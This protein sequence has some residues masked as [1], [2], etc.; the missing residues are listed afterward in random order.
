MAQVFKNIATA[1]V[2]TSA[3]EAVA[4]GYFRR[5]EGV[6]FDR[7]RQLWEAKRRA[8][9]LAD[10]GH[11]PPVPRSFKLP[12]ESGIATLG[13][14]VNTMIASGHATEHDGVIARKL[15]TVLCGGNSGATHEVSEEEILV[16]EREAFV[17]LCGEPKTQERIQHMLMQ[18]KPLRN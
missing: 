8:I 3:G 12:G 16:L 2:A 10:A 7:A 18:N 4:A 17:S 9:G 1:R 5:G 15:A 14:L 11:H 6:S 13:L